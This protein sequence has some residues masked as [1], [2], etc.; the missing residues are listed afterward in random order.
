MSKVLLEKCL[1]RWAEQSASMVLQEIPT[2]Q[3]QVPHELSCTAERLEGMYR[4]Q[5]SRSSGGA[6]RVALPGVVAVEMLQNLSGLGVCLLRHR[7]TDLAARD[8]PSP[9]V[10]VHEAAGVDRAALAAS[11]SSGVSSAV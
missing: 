9:L 7:E 1:L 6:R 11:S 10:E 5:A 3:T 2:L 4:S 8:V